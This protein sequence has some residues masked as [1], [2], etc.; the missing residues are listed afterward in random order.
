M[1]RGTV[2]AALCA[3]T[4]VA[5]ISSAA[6]IQ[7][8]AQPRAERGSVFHAA[9]RAEARAPMAEAAAPS[10]E[11]VPAWA[12][13]ALGLALGFAVALSGAGAASAF[14]DGLVP[15][16]K[17]SGSGVD[18]GVKGIATYQGPANVRQPIAEVI[19][20]PKM[21]SLEKKLTGGKS[22]EVEIALAERPIEITRDVNGFPVEKA[23]V[24]RASN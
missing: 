1:A 17:F 3:A 12:G 24:R 23:E 22:S 20:S 16:D 2:A 7:P 18:S 4:I 9:W 11:S 6:F 19:F 14:S 10:E 21:Q 5:M 8:S 15:P 13:L